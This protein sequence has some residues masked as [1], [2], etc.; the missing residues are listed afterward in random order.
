MSNPR[1]RLKL[2]QSVTVVGFLALVAA[3]VHSQQARIGVPFQNAGHSFHEN[4]NLSWGLR[5][6]GMFFRFNAPAPPPFGG[7]GPNSQAMVGGGFSGGNSGGF[8]QLN[9]SQGS[10]TSF[11]SQ[12]VSGTMLD[13]ST[14]VVGDMSLR[15]FVTSVIPVVSDPSPLRE[16]LRRTTELQANRLAG[17][18]RADNSQPL[19]SASSLP[20]VERSSAASGDESV[21]AIRA[22]QSQEDAARRGEADE[23]LAKARAARE[24]G[25]FAVARIHY[26][27]VLR[28]ISGEEAQ[29]VRV[30]AADLES[31]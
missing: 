18:T 20:P 27:Q 29:R 15:P 19:H 31:P 1:C 21:A 17:E 7:F 9:A 26:Q 5:A 2:L 10:N 22:R 11:G 3:P 14:M 16:R 25:K 8:F 28:R 13:G 4:V 24:Q 12:T 23:L 6:P 30:E